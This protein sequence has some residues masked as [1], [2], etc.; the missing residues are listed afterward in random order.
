MAR[1]E[2]WQNIPNAVLREQEADEA[3]T[4]WGN[5][6]RDQLAKQWGDIARSEVDAVV[7]AYG[8]SLQPA[9]PGQLVDEPTAPHHGYVY[10]GELPEA[11]EPSEPAITIHNPFTGEDETHKGIVP[12]PLTAGLPGFGS[13]LPLLP[14]SKPPPDR[15]THREL[16]A[17]DADLG[18]IGQ[19]EAFNTIVSQGSHLPAAGAGNLGAIGS[20]DDAAPAVKSLLREGPGIPTK[21]AQAVESVG[22]VVG[23]AVQPLAQKV[24]RFFHGTGSAFDTP[25]PK[26]FDPTGMYGPAY[27]VTSDARVAGSYATTRSADANDV[28][29]LRTMLQQAEDHVAFVKRDP[30]A[31]TYGKPE[32]HAKV[33][34]TAERDAANIRQAI[35]E[36]E[37]RID[38]GPNLR[39]VDVPENLNLFDVDTPANPDDVQ[40]IRD[41]MLRLGQQSGDDPNYY[42]RKFVSKLPAANPTNQHLYE[43]LAEAFSW[44]EGDKKLR[45][46]EFANIALATLGY[47]G[48]RYGGGK[49]I[50]ITDDSGQPI[51]HEALAIFPS[52]LPRLRNAIS[53][54]PGGIVNGLTS[55]LSDLKAPDPARLAGAVGGSL[56]SEQL[57]PEGESTEQAW[58][59]R[60]GAAFGGAA[61]VRGVQ[62]AAR[63]QNPLPF[64]TGI[65]QASGI[66][67][68]GYYRSKITEQAQMSLDAAGAET[69]SAVDRLRTAR[70]AAM[71]SGIATQV[72]NNVSN[73]INLASDIGLKPLAAGLDAA[74]SLK[75]GERTRY[76]AEFGPQVLGTIAGFID[77]AREFPEVL[78]GARVAGKEVPTGQAKGKLDT[79]LEGVFRVMNA[80]DN[81]WR[82]ASEGGQAAAI[83]TRKATK[84][85]YTGAARA[86]RAHEILQDLSS[87]PDILDEMHEAGARTVFQETRDEIEPIL[88]VTRGKAGFF[89]DFVLPFVRTPYSVAAQQAGMSPA[90]V[91][92]VIK[93]ARDGK[94]GLTVDRAARFLAGTGAMGLAGALTASGFVTGPMPSDETERSTLPEG[95]KP[96]ALR[97]PS[98]DG[99]VYVPVMLFGP[100]GL[101]LAAGAILGDA[102]KRGYEG[103][104]N[105][106]ITATALRG[107]GKYAEDQLF[108][109]G[110]VT[111]AQL[112]TE[113]DK[114]LERF[115]EGMASQWSPA[116]LRQIDQILGRP[117]RDPSGPIEALFAGTGPI[118]SGLV[119]ERQTILGDA[120]LPTVTGLPAALVG[121]RVTAERDDPVLR[122]M[123]AA[124]VSISRQG[125]TAK[126][127]PLS[128]DDQRT[129]QTR[130]GELMRERIGPLADDE[131][132]AGFP[133][134]RR[135][136]ILERLRDK[137]FD[138]A[139]SEVLNRLSDDELTRRQ[140]VAQRARETR[141]PA[142]ALR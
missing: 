111:V 53:G 26:T 92:G 114:R 23:D 52:S 3:A 35:A 128:P 88:K 102:Y 74:A 76:Q 101:S 2:W 56:T 109:D 36:A 21:A 38:A 59:R 99:A 131:E 67:G 89:T 130:A 79:A 12:D 77:G 30:Y 69:P 104:N 82:S 13:G 33:L 73:A 4:A 1:R 115:V 29:P 119:K 11:P 25:D 49:R 18:E 141:Q 5:T 58:S 60:I 34:A 112:V 93:A 37:S 9:Y 65:T 85:G 127:L 81:L 50:P 71:L 83:A 27:Y 15:E 6:Q 95:W 45:N 32:D 138:D 140:G 64:D 133:L 113:P 31:S 62:R 7:K 28:A 54:A 125:D 135:G 63:G 100:F 132:F 55:G 116:A 136:R 107:L 86:Q 80:F 8:S 17:G 121:S 84:E 124:R 47:D 24:R 10:A 91:A 14:A 19:R 43:G 94:Q 41:A 103:Q 118:A 137:A 42:L 70:K 72:F 51:E 66:R 46:R 117:Y 16:I 105:E 22:Q 57:A 129:I 48:V 90:G 44:L 122:V 110:I 40:A 96:F 61:T 20:L 78:S 120:Q 108:L 87:H 97:V 68:P 139:R 75:T 106:R 126:R 39:A 134:E 98:G 123:R 142:E